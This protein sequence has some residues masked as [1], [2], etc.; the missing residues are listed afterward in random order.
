LPT[1]REL[2]RSHMGAW[3]QGVMAGRIEFHLLH[4]EE[5]RETHFSA[6]LSRQEVRAILRHA[7]G[8]EAQWRQYIEGELKGVPG[9]PKVGCLVLGHTRASGEPGYHVAILKEDEFPEACSFCFIGPSSKAGKSIISV[10]SREGWR[11]LSPTQAGEHINA[12]IALSALRFV[13]D[14]KGAMLVPIDQIKVPSKQ[15]PEDPECSR[16]LNL[17]FRRR[18]SLTK[19]TV[20]RNSVRLFSPEFAAT[21]DKEIVIR[22]AQKM[23]GTPQ[24]LLVYWDGTRFVSSDDEH[25]FLA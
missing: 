7:A 13:P 17:V 8:R 5:A 14:S 10:L 9:S 24:E 19:A 11:D 15:W 6:K 21:C 25:S 20:P 4:V 16:R 2:W 18:M 1:A 3:K 12:G 23:Q 22:I